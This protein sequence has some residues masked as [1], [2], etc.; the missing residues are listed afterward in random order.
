MVPRL[1]DRLSGRHER[2]RRWASSRSGDGPPAARG[3]AVAV[4]AVAALAAVAYLAWPAGTAPGAV[5]PAVRDAGWLRIVT[6]PVHAYLA[7]HTG[8]LAVTARQL[9]W[10]CAAAGLLLW[11]AAALLRTR[12]LRFLWVLYG[13]AGLAMVAAGSAP[14][15]R[16]TAAGIALTYWAVL[17]VPVLR[18]GR[19]PR[20]GRWPSADLHEAPGRCRRD[21]AALRTRLDRLEAAAWRPAVPAAAGRARH[22]WPAGGAAAAVLPPPAGP[23]RAGEGRTS[24]AGPSD[25]AVGGVVVGAAYR[26]DVPGALPPGREAELGE[27]LRR[28]CGGSFELTVTAVLAGDGPPLV[29]G[30]C[31]VQSGSADV[32]LTAE[33]AGAFGLQ[34]GVVYRVRGE[35]CDGDGN[36]VEMPLVTVVRVPARWLS[37]AADR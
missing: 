12:G 3:A 14:Q 2:A 21:L 26:V 9:E 37:P 17:T 11:P 5:W 32:E 35:L 24:D 1:S 18:R 30:M 34:P 29:E 23:A 4:T 6:D 33:Q 20:A 22:V 10:A 15:A 28:E 13:A 36:A 25:A 16:W 27:G 19:A 31:V 8:G 7:A